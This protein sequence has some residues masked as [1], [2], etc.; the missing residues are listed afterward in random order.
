MTQT[1]LTVEDGFQDCLPSVNFWRW[2]TGATPP[3]P[4]Q[5]AS[6]TDGL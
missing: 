3:E 4:M 1:S 2:P 6:S 5:M